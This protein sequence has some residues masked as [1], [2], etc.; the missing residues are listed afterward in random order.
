VT[1]ALLCSLCLGLAAPAGQTAGAEAAAAEAHDA[2]LRL[3]DSCL[4]SGDSAKAAALLQRLQP[5][6]D[7]DPRFAFDAVYRLVEHRELPLA[8]DL[9][10]R[11]AGRVR[12]KV[13]AASG[14]TLDV[15]ARRELEREM[16]E[17]AFVQGLI[18][19]AA[20]QKDEAVQ[21]LKIADGFGFPPLDSPQMVLAADA[22]YALEEYQF[23]GQAY[24]EVVKHN[25][26]DEQARLRL[27]ACLQSS[28]QLDTAKNELE[29]LL[30]R[31]P[32]HAEANYDL[33]AVLLDLKRE[34]DARERLERALTLDARCHRCM[35]KLAYVA[36]LAGDDQQCQAWLDKAMALDPTWVETNLVAGMLA[37]RTGRYDAAVRHLS[38]VVEEFPGHTQAQY[39]LALAYRRLG[40]AEKS[41][42]HLD[43][44]NRLILEH[45]AQTL[46]TRQ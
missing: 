14:R 31:H 18:A 8:R 1:A 5:E 11:I 12:D 15:D 25:P 9:W 39:Q 34:D 28:G 16:G 30:Q 35:A 6:L 2:Q 37:N 4:A 3:L 43:L 45:K 32:D 41:K 10:N 44:Y 21:F 40:D 20:R 33:G 26:D 13:Q 36:Y 24:Q 46:G 19:A 23:A 22:L 17:A 29:S 42:Q 38:R 27:A 7:S